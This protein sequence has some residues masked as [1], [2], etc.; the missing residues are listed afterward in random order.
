M[1]PETESIERNLTHLLRQLKLKAFQALDEEGQIGNIEEVRLL[2]KS[3][4]CPYPSKRQLVNFLEALK[5]S[6]GINEEA[7]RRIEIT[8]DEWNVPPF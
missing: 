1:Q 8:L 4:T 5:K 6:S 3:K 2:L 7:L